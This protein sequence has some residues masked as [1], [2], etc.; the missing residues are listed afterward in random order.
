M[1]EAWQRLLTGLI[2]GELAPADRQLAEKLL[3]QSA[4]A[5]RFHAALKRESDLLKKLPTLKAP[6][7]L[8]AAVVAKAKAYG[9]VR[10]ATLP[11]WR[12]ALP[13]AAA[14]AGL[15]IVVTLS[16]FIWGRFLEQD[17]IAKLES[18]R[19]PVALPTREDD[20]R[21]SN[22]DLLRAGERLAQ[23]FQN[24]TDRLAAGMSEAVRNQAERQAS[25][26]AAAAS[27][28]GNQPYSEVTKKFRRLDFSLPAILKAEELAQNLPTLMEGVKRGGVYQFD[29]ASENPSVTVQRFV[30]AGTD[31]QLRF[32]VDAEATAAMRKKQAL[33]YHIYVENLSPEA[34]GQVVSAFDAAERQ[35]LA[36][37]PSER[38]LVSAVLGRL[39]AESQRQLA[40]NLG[41]PPNS[42]VSGNHGELN[43]SPKF[44]P[45]GSIKQP[46]AP[47][48]QLVTGGTAV[49]FVHNPARKGQFASK[50]VRAFLDNRA[51]PQIDRVSLLIVVHAN[52]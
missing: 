11:F 23:A 47:S 20:V 7:D 4:E 8:S 39:E 46:T 42:I 41:V 5:R 22:G 26:V 49:V 25:Q 10:P 33:V 6:I 44:I 31:K 2:D 24:A 19:R 18:K 29:L 48:E 38:S 28:V 30:A 15:L 1:K 17:Q 21:L 51:G 13:Y 12:T 14:A 9:P 36:N 43:V 32:I 3:R 34:F 52:R 50:E 35:A 40:L 45:P 16:W 37:R 27:R